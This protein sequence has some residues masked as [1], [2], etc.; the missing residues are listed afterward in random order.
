MNGQIRRP[1]WWGLNGVFAGIL[2]LLYL[3]SRLSLSPFGHQAAL[4]MVVLI[5]YGALGM[6]VWWNR[7]ALSAS[8]RS[9]PAEGLDVWNAL[10][11]P[12]PVISG[13]DTPGNDR[14]EMESA[15]GRQL[16]NGGSSTNNT[17]DELT[18]RALAAFFLP[19]AI[20]VGLLELLPLAEDVRR[21]FGVGVVLVSLGLWNLCYGVLENF[22]ADLRKRSKR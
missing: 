2:A 7:E 19:L 22:Q 17:P 5:V 9:A 16:V 8:G 15:T 18:W 12:D 10:S 13:T 1:H 14:I 4:V 6:W 11:H 21:T 3:D 20:L